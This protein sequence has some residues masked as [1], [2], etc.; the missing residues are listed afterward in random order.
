MWRISGGAGFLHLKGSMG[1]AKVI[2]GGELTTQQAPGRN[3]ISPCNTQ[4]RKEAWVSTSM[5]EYVARCHMAPEK[6]SGEILA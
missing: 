4:Q 3:R 2:V 5:G 6:V 1:I